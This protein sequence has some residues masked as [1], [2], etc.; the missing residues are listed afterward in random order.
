MLAP[1][2]AVQGIAAAAVVLARP[3]LAHADEGGFLFL[4]SEE[5][6]SLFVYFAQTLISWGV[7]ALVLVLLIGVS[8]GGGKRGDDEDELPPPLA[9]FLGMSKEPKEFLSISQLSSKLDS[10]DY[11]LE[12]ASVSK[13]AALRT[14]LRRRFERTLGKEL[15]SLNLTTKQI[16]QIEK[17]SLRFAKIDGALKKQLESKKRVRTT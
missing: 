1:L 7:P 17:A 13:E 4:K 3:A 2:R 11:S 14:N 12:K 8:F 10:F 6:R 16:E 5:V 15:A 9:K